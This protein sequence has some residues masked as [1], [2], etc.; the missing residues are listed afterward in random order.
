[1][2]RKTTNTFLIV[3]LIA[4][5]LYWLFRSEPSINVPED[6]PQRVPP[7]I[8]EGRTAFLERSSNSLDEFEI[9][10]RIAGD[11]D[12]PAV[13]LIHGAA[14]SSDT[15]WYNTYQA[16]ENDYYVIAPDLRGHGLTMQPYAPTSIE[17]MADDV[18][19]LMQTLGIQEAHIVGH[20]MGGLV[21]MQFA[22]AHPDNALSLTLIDTT[23]GFAPS[24]LYKVGFALYPLYVRA[25]N[26]LTG[27]QQENHVRAI[28]FSRYEV[29][30]MY[31][32]WV[33]QKRS[34]NQTQP[35]VNWWRAIGEFDARDWLSEIKQPTLIIYG[36]DDDLIR[37]ELR[38][39][40]ISRFP[41]AQ[42]VTIAGA[43]HYPQIQF[44]EQV[45]SILFD[46]LGDN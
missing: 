10:Y 43:R 11:S 31:R 23:A 18:Y 24:K 45:N 22:R 5:F 32:E 26:R 17:E 36:K 2:K 46:F 35:F 39:E 44:A 15:T 41:H 42:V 37:T 8:P 7:N 25:Q 33:F 29:D 13:I 28:S 21:T 20:S 4:G 1:M 27:W 19:A 30:P 3:V 40:L 16:L 12:N 38:E 14:G 6:V 9:F 34:F